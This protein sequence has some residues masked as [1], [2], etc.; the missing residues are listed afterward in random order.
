MAVAWLAAWV[1]GGRAAAQG[2]MF[3]LPG[4]RPARA[5][6]TTGETDPKLVEAELAN[7]MW[8]ELHGVVGVVGLKEL[9]ELRR[10]QGP[11]AEQSGA[12]RTY[13]YVHLYGRAGKDGGEEHRVVRIAQRED[14]GFVAEETGAAGAAR[15]FALK[16][17]VFVPVAT[18]WAQCR[19]GWADGGRKQVQAGR[20]FTLEPPHAPGLWTM[21]TKVLGERFLAGGMTTLKPTGR[22]MAEVKIQ[23]RLP[24]G[25]AVD[26]AAGLIVWCDAGPTGRPPEVFASVCDELG[27]IIAGAEDAGNDRPATDRY[28][29]AMDVA[30]TVRARF[31]VDPERVYLSGISGGG[32][33]CSTL[34]ACFPEMFSG[35]AP[36]VGLS[37]FENVPDGL[38]RM[39]PGAFR[40]P[41]AKI[42]ELFKTRR[43]GVLTGEQDFNY[44]EIV[45]A[46]AVYERAG[47]SVRVFEI[48]GM[49]HQMGT[50]E[51]MTEVV[52]W[53]DE[54]HA[55][56]RAAGVARARE[57]LAQ[58]A[59]GDRVGLLGVMAAAPW[60]EPAWEAARRLGVK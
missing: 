29:L 8:R 7:P 50:A 13:A 53:I 23:C 39:W 19:G 42:F 31:L 43:M 27:L 44:P 45:G 11:R 1:F 56:E 14:G 2:G 54:R 22:A 15:R 48:P 17:E 41:P 3:D 20:V 6:V 28:Q 33:V 5:V 12:E 4:A 21:T 30:A 26:R 37:C 51:Q 52:R 10:S 38:G 40:R 9:V 18:G 16:D 32:R 59:D 36:V 55:A 24:K 58:C 25:F 57:L 34:A 46:A 47:C 35:S 60:S 49:G